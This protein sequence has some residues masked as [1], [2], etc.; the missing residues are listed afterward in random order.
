METSYRDLLIKL[1]RISLKRFRGRQ[2]NLSHPLDIYPMKKDFSKY[3]R[4]HGDM[5]VAYNLLHGHLDIDESLFFK[6]SWNTTRGKLFKPSAV[7][8]VRRRFFSQQVVL[9]WNSLPCDVVDANSVR[10]FKARFDDHNKDIIYFY[11]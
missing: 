5:I 6:R 7:K 9:E 2:L 8:E 10:I 4:F 1:T 11:D 3:R